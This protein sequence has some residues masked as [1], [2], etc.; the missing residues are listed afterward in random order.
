LGKDSTARILHALLLGLA[1]WLTFS[2]AVVVLFTPVVVRLNFFL[3]PC[4]IAV[5]IV[6]LVLLRLGHLRAASLVYLVGMW[7]YVTTIIVLTGGIRNAP[8]L[9]FYASL[10]ISAAWLF[11]YRATLWIA[12]LCISATLALTLLDLGGVKLY[13]YLPAKP[14]A[15]WT[16]LV[17]AILV[18]AIPV[19]QVLKTLRD[20]LAQSQRTE[21]AL[22]ESRL[23]LASVYDT[24]RDVIFHLA[25]EPGA[26]SVSF[27]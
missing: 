21:A 5:L 12:G 10:P 13:P 1:L 25:V 14:L 15:A 6:A 8:G 2:T 3:V 26:N 18:A 19:A 7:L 4:L 11:G 23:R 27:R 22:W 16:F 20:S 24:V 17:M 9:V